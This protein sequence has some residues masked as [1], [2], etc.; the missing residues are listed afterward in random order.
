M[1][2]TLHMWKVLNVTCDV[3]T[4]DVWYLNVTM[5]QCCNVAFSDSIDRFD[6]SRIRLFLVKEKEVI[7]PRFLNK[8]LHASGGENLVVSK[9]FCTFVVEIQFFHKEPIINN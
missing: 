5:L 3:V 9:M 8:F 1:E 4:R 6:C 2:G 7:F